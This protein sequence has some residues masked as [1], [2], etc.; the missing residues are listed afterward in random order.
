MSVFLPNGLG[1]STG[2]DYATASPVYIRGGSAGS[3]WYVSAS[4]SDAANGRDRSAPLET[5]QAAI[6]AATAGDT[7]VLM[8]GYSETIATQVEIDKV[9][10]IVGE[11]A[12]SGVP[13]PV[14]TE[15]AGDYALLV[16]ANSVY[17]AGVKIVGRAIDCTGN[18]L[19]LEDCYFVADGEGA[20]G[21]GSVVFG[22]S[23]VTASLRDCTFVADK[24]GENIPGPAVD[25]TVGMTGLSIEGCTFRCG[26]ADDDH[27]ATSGGERYAV[28]IQSAATCL[29]GI[30]NTLTNGAD[31]FI[32]ASSTGIFHVSSA[33]GSSRV[34]W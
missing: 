1:A 5:L 30:R 14:I 13:S 21:V 25:V 2:A 19:A 31:V 7:I 10:T 24:S 9:L 23:A 6:T 20:S 32:H 22:G 16:S 18:D 12:S 4:G 29:R 17:I 27:F 15:G 11:G 34:I 8:S 26:T 33:T 28:N 3:V